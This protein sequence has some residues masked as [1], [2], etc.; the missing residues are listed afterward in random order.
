MD[1]PLLTELNKQN[2]RYEQ[3]K[4]FKVTYTEDYSNTE[5]QTR[6]TEPDSTEEADDNVEYIRASDAFPEED[7][8][9]F[10]DPEGLIAARQTKHIKCVDRMS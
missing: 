2:Q 5:T 3:P 10:V 4:T 1:N 6:E 8:F 9:V 7:F